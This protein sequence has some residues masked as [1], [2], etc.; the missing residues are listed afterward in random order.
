M[1][2]DNLRVSQLLLLLLNKQ[3]SMNGEDGV[4]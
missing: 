2:C 4:V 1:N 3:Y